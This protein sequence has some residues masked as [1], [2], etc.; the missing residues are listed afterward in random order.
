M[1][2]IEP[3]KPFG[4]GSIS[5]GVYIHGQPA[6]EAAAFLVRQAQI[7]E[8]VG[9]D[10]VTISE[11]HGGM[12][13]YI[14]D[15]IMVAC[16]MLAAT[17]RIWAGPCPMLLSL[18]PAWLVAEQMAWLN[19]RFPGRVGGGFGPGS[20]ATTIDYEIA[21]VDRDQRRKLFAER[22]PVLAACLR[23]EAPGLLAGD[24]AI[25]ACRD[26]PIPILSTVGGPLGAKRAGRL[27]IGLVPS[28]ATPAEGL[29]V[30]L[31]PYREAGGAGPIL[32]NRRAW[33][34][35][36]DAS[37]LESLNAHY[38]T[39]PLAADAPG[40]NADYIA[41]EDP[42]EVARGLVNAL[43]I[44]GGTAVNIKFFYRELA[45]EGMARQLHDFGETVIPHFRRRIAAAMG[46]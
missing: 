16:W 45:P 14:P 26:N 34:G 8:D 11:H 15:P 17:R 18:R 37:R 5:V 30:F 3:S 4:R 41:S 31:D 6:Q 13:E 33:L 40:F 24:P 39:R 7:A 28:S 32:I 19:A 46:G 36:P 21:G 10:G 9:F 25:Q 20:V 38:Q 12:F 2:P 27:G 43:A 35:K 29:H 23:G 1:P 22:L 42:D 44:S